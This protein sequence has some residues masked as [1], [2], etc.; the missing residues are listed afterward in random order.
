[1]VALGHRPLTAEQL[2]M[3]RNMQNPADVV[4]PSARSEIPGDVYTSPARFNAEWKGIFQKGPVPLGVSGWLPK[5]GMVARHDAYGVPMIVTR[6][7]DGVI[8]A[9]LNVCRHR[10]T[11]LCEAHEPKQSLRLVCP[12]HAWTYGLDGTL[13][14][15]PRQETFPGLDKATMGLIPLQCEEA[16]GII[17]VGLDKDEKVDFEPIR[18]AL[19]A[20]LTALDIPRMHLHASKTYEVPANWKL[21]IDAFLEGYHVTRL[22]SNSVGKFFTEYPTSYEQFGLHIRV[23]SARGNFEKKDI[24]GT[25]E[26]I[27]RTMV[28]SYHLFP[29]SILITSPTY[30]NLM[31]VV[32]RSHS[33]SR[34]EYFMLTDEKPD[35]EKSISHFQRSFDLIDKVFGEEDFRAAALGQAGLETGALENLTLGGLEQTLRLFHDRVDE[36]V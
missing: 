28:V 32:P 22:H 31:I 12:Y 23:M 14:G 29:N 24:G 9:F 7:K 13:I 25:Y 30:I 18:G 11:L 27:R 2:A 16:G 10:G 26:S 6:A 17:W 33:T 36:R 8:R 35:T 34:V 15:V 3:L 5:P 4:M 20:E 21:I 1:M 19:A